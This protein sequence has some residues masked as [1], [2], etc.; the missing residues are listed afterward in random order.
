LSVAVTVSRVSGVQ[1]VVVNDLFVEL[2]VGAIVSK[3]GSGVGV[4]FSG[5][6]VATVTSVVKVCSSSSPVLPSFARTSNVAI[7]V[8]S[9]KLFIVKLES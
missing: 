7:I 1:T 5:V 2:R 3:T 8:P 6:G 4:G 9:G